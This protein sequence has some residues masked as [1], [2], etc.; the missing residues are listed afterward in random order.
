MAGSPEFRQLSYFRCLLFGFGLNA[1]V[2]TGFPDRKITVDAR[3]SYPATCGGNKGV[4]PLVDY[5]TFGS[6]FIL[7]IGCAS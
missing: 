6:T 1:I 3:R 7:P 4:E 5:P 2:N